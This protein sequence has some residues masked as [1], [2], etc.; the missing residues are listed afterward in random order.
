M[1]IEK[2]IYFAPVWILLIL[3]MWLVIFRPLGPQ[4]ALIPGDLGDARFN[5]YIL[6]HFYHWA[7]GQTQD[8]WNAPFFFPFQQT[9]SFSDNL[10]GSAPFY[11]LFRWIGLQRE[12]AF[13]AW[14]IFGYILNYAAASYVMIRSKFRPL[15]VGAGA[16]FFTFGLPLLAQENHVQLLF[17]FCIPLACFTLWQFYQTPRLKTLV[18]LGF[19]MI[20]QMYLTIYMGIFLVLLL[21]IFFVL[22]P[23]FVPERTFMQ[24]IMIWPKRLIE[25]WSQARF[26]DRFFAMSAVIALFFC[27]TALFLPYYRAQQ[28]YGFYRNWTEVSS[29]LPR[30]KSFLLADN[31]QL[32]NSKTNISSNLPLRHEHQLFPG[33]AVLILVLIGMV[34]RFQTENRRLAWLNL[35]AA[36]VFVALTLEI[37]GFSLYEIIWR[38]PGMSSIRAVT[39]SMLVVMWPLAFFSAWTIDGFLQQVNQQHRWRQA[40]AYLLVGFLMAESIFYNHATFRKADVQDRLDD[41]RQLIPAEVPSNP[42]LF[43]ALNPK[44]PDWAGEID[45]MLLAQELGWATFNGYSGNSPPGY[46]SAESCDQ[47]PARIKNYMDF[48]RIEDSNYY[49]G[50]MKRVVALGFMDCNLSWWEKMP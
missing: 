31:S 13:Q 19:W 50:I 8:Y 30:W 40:A 26:T 33:A 44:E 14:Y 47:L 6:E 32:W 11:A 43:V 25:A 28:N 34:G 7:T 2:F 41:L 3:G 39:R 38:M 1:K 4:L 49:L 12:S 35:Y 15:A 9:I 16:F 10:L 20:W 27:F 5:N 22:L 18:S 24:R 36:I 46:Q 17:R 45:V 37:H 23:F 21:G 48:A 42:I 29:M